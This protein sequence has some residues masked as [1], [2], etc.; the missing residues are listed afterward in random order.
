VTLGVTKREGAA[1]K[2]VERVGGGCNN[3]EE[4]GSARVGDVGL[5]SIGSRSKARTHSP[6]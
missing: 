3:W 2:G 6:I 1:A 5:P 4:R